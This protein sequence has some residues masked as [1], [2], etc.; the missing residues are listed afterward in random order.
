MSVH[1]KPTQEQVEAAADKCREYIKY[2]WKMECTE[3]RS[4]RGSIYLHAYTDNGT[5]LFSIRVSDHGPGAKDNG[6]DSIVCDPRMDT[7]GTLNYVARK[8]NLRDTRDL[9]QYRAMNRAMNKANRFL[10]SAESDKGVDNAA[11]LS[12]I[13]HLM[14]SLN[15]LYAEN[16]ELREEL[17]QS[18]AA[19]AEAQEFVKGATAAQ[20]RKL[21]EADQLKARVEELEA[22][23]KKWHTM[24]ELL[25]S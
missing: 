17:D 22:I 3:H 9:R 8:F 1:D 25:W 10:E 4:E 11:E 20:Q 13:D 24:K 15:T 14:S 21:A 2:V 5:L 23:E 16:A 19:L 12:V 18:K 6:D 7:L